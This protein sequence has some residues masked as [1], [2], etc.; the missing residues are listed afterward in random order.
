MDVVSEA[1]SRG[2]VGARWFDAK[3][4]RAAIE[5]RAADRDVGTREL[6]IDLGLDRRTVQRLLLR[7]RLR[8]DTAD[9]IAVALGKHPSELWPEW[10][11]QEAV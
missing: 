3:P 11:A 1:L 8:S 10:F 5:R 4:A 7:D 2:A 9:R 6:A